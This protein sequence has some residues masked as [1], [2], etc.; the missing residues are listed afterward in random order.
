MHEVVLVSVTAHNNGF[1]SLSN[2]DI[3]V[4]HQAPDSWQREKLFQAFFFLSG[5]CASVKNRLTIHQERN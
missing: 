5:I 1:S 3:E 4:L 2:D